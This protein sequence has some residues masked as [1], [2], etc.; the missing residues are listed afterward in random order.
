MD[1]L[2]FGF[3]TGKVI[4]PGI[5]LEVTLPSN[6]FFRNDG[7]VDNLREHTDKIYRD[8]GI[9][10]DHA[11]NLDSGYAASNHLLDNSGN[12][13]SVIYIQDFSKYDNL[14][15]YGHESTHAAHILGLEKQFCGMLKH[16]GFSLDPFIRFK[17]REVIADIGGVIALYKKFGEE[18]FDYKLFDSKLIYLQRELFASKRRGIG[19]YIN[20]VIRSLY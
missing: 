20:S 8:M 12:I 1:F 13:A 6:R 5:D 18:I 10:L 7:I 14:F 15:N 4:L 19:Y 17:D 9:S 11:H 3:Q 16:E 2:K